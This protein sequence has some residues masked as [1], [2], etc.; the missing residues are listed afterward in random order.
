MDVLRIALGQRRG[1]FFSHLQK[2]ISLALY[3]WQNKSGPR[4][5]TNWKRWS[6]SKSIDIPIRNRIW[7]WIFGKIYL[8][9]HD[10]VWFQTVVTMTGLHSLTKPG[11]TISG[12]YRSAVYESF[13]DQTRVNDYLVLHDRGLQINRWPNPNKRSPTLSVVMI[14]NHSLIKPE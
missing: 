11:H 7:I 3:I 10:A 14:T 6:C 9:L 13:A 8:E 5:D 4:W 1:H 2:K 12:S